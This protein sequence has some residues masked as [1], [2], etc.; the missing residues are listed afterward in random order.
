MRS[1]VADVMIVPKQYDRRDAIEV[2]DVRYDRSSQIEVLKI[3]P[4]GSWHVAFERMRWEE[5]RPPQKPLVL[6]GT[7]PSRAVGEQDDPTT[8]PKFIEKVLIHPPGQYHRASG[9]P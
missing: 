3:D 9:A 4:K 7:T 5:G 1:D 8:L 2:P 6:N